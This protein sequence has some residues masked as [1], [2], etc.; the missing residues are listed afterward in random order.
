MDLPSLKGFPAAEVAYVKAN[1]TLP[2]FA[3]V[4]RLLVLQE[5][6]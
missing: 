5:R 3:V 6:F 1:S 4:E 2:S